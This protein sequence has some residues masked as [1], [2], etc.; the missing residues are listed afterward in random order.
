MYITVKPENKQIKVSSD[1]V[2]ANSDG[3][4]T[5]EFE[6][7]TA[8][9]ITVTAD[10]DEDVEGDHEVKITHTIDSDSAD[11]YTKSSVKIS[12]SSK[13]EVNITD[14]DKSL[15][16]ISSD[17]SVMEGDDL[18][19]KDIKF[20]VTLSKAN[21]KTVTVYYKI[22]GVTADEGTDYKVENP[23]DYTGDELTFAPDDLTKN[24]IVK[25]IGDE[26]SEPN[27]KFSVKL[28]DKPLVGS[29]TD[30]NMADIDADNKEKT[31]TITNDDD[32]GVTISTDTV[33]VTEGSET[34]YTVKLN[35]FPTDDVKINLSIDDPFNLIQLIN[36]AGDDIIT[37]SSPLIF[38]TSNGKT[39][40]KVKVVA[41]HDKVATNYSPVK[42]TH[43]IET[44]AEAY[45]NASFSPNSEV[46]VNIADIDAEP[47]SIT[48]D[49]GTRTYG[50]P[51]FTGA[52][53]PGGTVKLITS[54][55]PSVAT[56]NKSNSTVR[57]VGVGTTQICGEVPKS[58]KYLA[59][60]GCG[61]LT[62]NK[63][64]LTVTADDKTRPYNTDNPQFTM[65][66]SGWV[67]SDNVSVL[68]TPPTLS[69]SATKT[70]NAGTYPIVIGGGADDHYTFNY[71]NSELEITQLDQTIT[72]YD[73]LPALV[74]HG[75]N[76]PLNAQ[77]SSGLSVI[78]TS[79]TPEVALISR[80]KVNPTGYGDA[81]ICATQPGNTN[82]NEAPELCQTITINAPPVISE[83][84]AV[85]VNM[86]EDSDPRSFSLSLNATDQD[87]DNSRIR[88]KISKSPSHGTASA[89][90]SGSD[91]G[92]GYSPAANWSG[93]DSF[94]VQAYD[95]RGGTDII[96]VT[97]KVAA[98]NDAPVLHSHLS[99]E[100]TAIDEDIDPTLNPGNTVAEILAQDSIEDVDGTPRQAI[101]VIAVDNTNGVW[102][103]STD[104]AT[105][106]SDFSDI[107]GDN[108]TLEE[109][110]V[111]ESSHKIRFLPN[112][113]YPYGD[114]NGNAA[115]TFRAWD[116]TEGTAGSTIK[117]TGIGGMT[118]FSSAQDQANITVNPLDDA[119]RVVSPILDITVLEDARDTVIDLGDVFTDI[120]NNDLLIVE[121][122]ETIEESNVGPLQ[123]SPL[124]D[125]SIV[126]DIL[127]IAYESHQYGQAAVT[128]LATSAE[129]TVKDQFN[130][131][132][133]SETDPPAI[134]IHQFP[135]LT[136]IEE[137]NTNSPGDT[138]GDMV[139][140]LFVTKNGYT[141]NECTA[142]DGICVESEG[143][144]TDPD[145]PNTEAV[146]AIAVIGVNNTMGTWQ[147]SLDNGGTWNDFTS[148]TGRFVNTDEEARVLTESHKVRF[149]PNPNYYGGSSF[150]FRA[151]DMTDGTTPGAVADVTAYGGTSA[152]SAVSDYAQIEVTPVDNPPTV[153][154]PMDDVFVNMN[155]GNRTINL[156]DVFTDIDNNPAT[157]TKQLEENTN[158]NLVTPFVDKNTLTLD[159]Q[160]DKVGQAVI[161]IR[162]QSNGK[163]VTDSFTVTVSDNQ[164][165]PLP[166]PGDQHL[167]PIPEDSFSNHG[168]TVADIFENVADE[169][170]N[171]ITAI[172]VTS[173]NNEFGIWQ[174]ALENFEWKNFTSKT[175]GFID[176]ENET[177]V[178]DSSARIRFVPDTDYNGESVFRFQAYD[179][180]NGGFPGQTLISGRR[181]TIPVPDNRGI[182]KV[183]PVDDPPTVDNPIENIM[184]T[185]PVTG[186][187]INLS[188][189]FTDV[190]VDNDDRDIIKAVE[191]NTNPSLVTA[192]I[193]RNTLTLNMYD[194]QRGNAVIR[195]RGTSNG[196]TV[197]DEFVVMINE[198][199]VLDADHS[200][201][202]T[203]IS[204][205]ETENDGDS[206]GDILADNSIT[207]ADGSP[208]KA[209]AVT[210]VDNTNGAWQYSLDHGETW[211]DFSLLTE[212]AD[213]ED[214]AVLLEE[215]NRIRFVPDTDYHG[216]TT[217]TFR[218][219]DQNMGSPGKRENTSENGGAS[220]FSEHTNIATLFVS[221]VDDPPI[222]ARPI[223][224]VLM[225]YET[226]GKKID[227]SDVFTDADNDDDEILKTV[228]GNDNSSLVYARVVDENILT[229]SFLKDQA[230]DALVTIT[231]T[232]NGK[233][234]SDEFMVGL[235][236]SNYA[237]ILDP[238]QDPKLN[239][240]IRN[241]AVNPGTC[242][243]DIVV[244]G[245]VADIDTE[246]P[247]NAIAVIAADNTYGVWQYSLDNGDTWNDFAFVSGMS[248]DMETQARLLDGTLTDADTHKIRFVPDEDFTGL[249]TVTFRAYDK[250]S[251]TPGE[252]ADA[253]INGGKTAFSSAYDDAVIMVNSCV[254]GETLPGDVDDSGTIDLLD[255]II[256]LK[257]LVGK[258]AGSICIYADVNGDGRIGTDEAVY[259][260][261][262]LGSDF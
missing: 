163:T 103:Y 29:E 19:G 121:T 127:T 100:L 57:I 175:G 192:L 32:P 152:F 195:V 186:R 212:I 158:W 188:N 203:D 122:I 30:S 54:S 131:T 146:I 91:K 183:R 230:G 85:T 22:S 225:N 79:K 99:P 150:T 196:K 116:M 242:V 249:S 111:L 202:L 38:K 161:T 200:P 213:L 216:V 232:S 1:G 218:A 12:P 129:K 24:I 147:Y 229:L 238:T 257:T 7:Q 52:T 4:I 228:T 120:D 18:V 5:L 41:S 20:K 21:P 108:I 49:L 247:V 80:N 170:G 144:I 6:N 253:S 197:S 47:Q 209:M 89:S 171:L 134:P 61:T 15:I 33:N 45:I 25:I 255:A 156:A 8:K 101:A 224:D 222:V 154:R 130:I 16:S 148:V 201:L 27:E 151:W 28:L 217:F 184:V 102:Q 98:Q 95:T 76:I 244:H 63:K 169:N 207:D 211:H 83:G 96:T 164:E 37:T 208:R 69:C 140:G 55:N 143:F 237:P 65:S 34:T 177:R 58:V 191:S 62:V 3:S 36:E 67:G 258:N 193:D 187:T 119:P 204:E 17:D 59:A 138:V 93:T 142:D 75:D 174:Y 139:S 87:G 78:F 31:F 254:A 117:I 135:V 248:A 167:T 97:V 162:G 68:D 84:S 260:L 10:D 234:V 128:I 194:S 125:L 189:V 77:A 166:A 60:S 74:N 220:P 48:F 172:A 82:Y 226:S 64:T 246:S 94:Q 245:S 23:Y 35:T 11:E 243:A 221:S 141:Y 206:V 90:G 137:N 215:T 251:G 126:G 173:V 233:S 56:V 39:P 153:F 2:T 44:N 256:I 250:T 66:Y 168:D 110:R 81:V 178:L 115:F 70:S 42:I 155:A 252:T 181:D 51:A 105:Q 50:D 109:A 40:Q 133:H 219:W 210:E 160:Q 179:L 107:R 231:G 53:A 104:S 261:R 227:L 159:F 199:P 190:D 223:A 86:D 132:V 106:W 149:V 71:I 92:I 46:T 113:D 259:V 214:N 145:I 157:I 262:Q 239:D 136:S 240:I 235:N 43:T 112:P 241:P 9:S 73:P 182:I 14:N 123:D 72:S 176:L 13:V 236:W 118:P 185:A 88:W 114:Y 205:D 26:V 198:A 165:Q 124:L 180:S